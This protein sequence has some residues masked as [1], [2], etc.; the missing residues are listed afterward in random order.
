MQTLTSDEIGYIT[1]SFRAWCTA[2]GKS[3]PTREDAE[4]Y[5]IY[6]QHNEPFIAERIDDDWD[7]FVAFLTERRLLL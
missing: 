7:D 1:A 6:V 4:A 5:F 2:H 3:A